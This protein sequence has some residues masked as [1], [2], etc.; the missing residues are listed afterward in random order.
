MTTNNKELVVEKIDNGTVI[1]HIPADKVFKIVRILGLEAY[2]DEILIGTNLCSKKYGK[3]G[4]L[5]IKNIYFS[6]DEFDKIA[7]ICQTATIIIIK[8]YE[9]EQKKHLE[10]PKHIHKIVKCINPNCI[11]NVEEIETNFDVVNND[12]IQI[13]CHYCEKTMEEIIFNE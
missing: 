3:K 9:V 2:E 13:Q 4:I 6:Q 12:P 11:T 5:K 8:N 7:I 10:I 1:D